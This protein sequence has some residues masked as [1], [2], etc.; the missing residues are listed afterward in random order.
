MQM[1]LSKATLSTFLHSRI[2]LLESSGIVVSVSA[3]RANQSTLTMPCSQVTLFIFCLSV[4]SV[5]YITVFV[6]VCR[7]QIS[8]NVHMHKIWSL[9][10]ADTM[11]RSDSL[12]VTS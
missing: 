9:Y 6:G 3:S 2:C 1:Y 10:D 4:R 12:K 5:R 11:P 8:D 7:T